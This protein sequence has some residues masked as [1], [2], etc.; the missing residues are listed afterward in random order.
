MAINTKG[1]ESLLNPGTASSTTTKT[2]ASTGSADTLGK[3]DFLKLL[4]TELQHQDPT[5]PMDSDKILTQTS[6]L[7]TLESATKTNTA[8]D[9]LSSQ[10]KE[11]VSANATNLI[12]KM[13][14]L[15]YNAITLNNSTA[16]YEV[17]FPTEIKSGTLSI[18][19]KDKNVVQTIDLKD[20][21]GKSGVI[22]FEWDG[23]NK[24]GEQLKDGYYG[25]TAEYLDKNNDQQ[26]TQ[27][28]VYPVESVRY[29]NGSSYIK[30]G[31]NYFPMSDVVE[32]YDK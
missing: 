8:L 1:Y 20:A 11:S 29:D 28:G 4:L 5:S 27:F 12:G 25:V 30:L 16:K 9:N 31:S 21:V 2:A 13:G 26:K 18:T 7:A 6:Q 32:Y 14:S 23:K 22:S 15:G 10:L 24:Y 17:Y 3:D 19:D